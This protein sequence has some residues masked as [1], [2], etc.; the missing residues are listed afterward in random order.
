MWRDRNAAV[1][2]TQTEKLFPPTQLV[3]K[4]VIS[5]KTLDSAFRGRCELAT[6][7]MSYVFLVAGF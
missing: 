1:K 6:G 4:H 3:Q 7:G 5:F 2:T